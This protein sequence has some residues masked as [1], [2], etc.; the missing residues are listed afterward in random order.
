M[1]V[2]L[3]QK[4]EVRTSKSFQILL[5]LLRHLTLVPIKTNGML[6]FAKINIWATYHLSGMILIG[7]IAWLL[8]Y[9]LQ[10]TQLAILT[11]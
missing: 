4:T 8:Q 3:Y 10:M 11:R 2:L 6:G 1:V 5:E 7:K 9:M